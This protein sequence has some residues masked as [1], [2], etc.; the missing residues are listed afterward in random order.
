MLS[1]LTAKVSNIEVLILNI[2]TE[3]ISMYTDKHPGKIKCAQSSH[4][5]HMKL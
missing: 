1:I 2:L 3:M 5:W 4:E